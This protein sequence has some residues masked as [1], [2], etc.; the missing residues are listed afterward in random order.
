MRGEPG[1]GKKAMI[2]RWEQHIGHQFTE[3]GE[4][5]LTGKMSKPFQEIQDEKV[6]FAVGDK[7]RLTD[8]GLS[9]LLDESGRLPFEVNKGIMTEVDGKFLPK[10]ARFGEVEV[11]I[12]EGYVEKSL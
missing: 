3:Q 6:R 8:I 2:N 12:G 10:K 11:N 5:N 9:L 1:A 4:G 7:V